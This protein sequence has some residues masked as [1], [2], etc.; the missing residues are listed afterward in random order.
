M[1]KDQTAEG[2]HQEPRG[3]DAERRQ[4]RRNRVFCREELPPDHGSEIAVDG[5]IVPFHHI[6][7]DPGENG[8]LLLCPSV[9][10]H[11]PTSRGGRP[12]LSGAPYWPITRFTAPA[13]TPASAASNERHLCRH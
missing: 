8:A 1:T 2:P 3:E 11:A 5:K 13:V 10:V 4:Q 12:A 7:G 9:L 6:A